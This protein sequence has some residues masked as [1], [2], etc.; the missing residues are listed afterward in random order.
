MTRIVAIAAAMFTCALIVTQ[1]TATAESGEIEVS[2]TSST[3]D[4]GTTTCRLLGLY[5][6]SCKTTGFITGFSGT[7]VGS[8]STD[9]KPLIDCK[10]GRYHGE[11]TETF[12][13]TVVG[14]GSG[15]LTWR[16]RFSGDVAADCSELTSFEGTGV[17]VDGTGDLEGLN[18]T[19]SF[20]ASTYTG[21]LH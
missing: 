5:V 4:P 8:S 15:T 6:V 7:L 14:V 11:G 16:L 20:T 13:G 10:T 21:S 12:T 19:L 2:G 3:P 18:G 17:V 1:T 9:D